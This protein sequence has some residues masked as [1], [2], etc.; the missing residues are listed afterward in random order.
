MPRA[1]LID[2]DGTLV[3]PIPDV[4]LAVAGLLASEQLP[5]LSQDQVRLMAARAPRV[6]ERRARYRARG[7]FAAVQPGRH[8]RDLPTSVRPHDVDARRAGR[9]AVLLG[10]GLY[11]GAG[12]QLGPGRHRDD[13]P[14]F[15][16]GRLVHRHHRGQQR[17]CDGDAGALA[18]TGHSDRSAAPPGRVTATC[19]DDRQQRRRCP[20]CQ[21]RRCRGDR[22]SRRLFERAARDFFARC[23]YRHHW[24]GACALRARLTE[25]AAG[26]A[27]RPRRCDVRH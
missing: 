4:T 18:A 26:P 2:L 16:R 21:G 15:R 19:R 5:P 14:T 27:S 1:V 12:N 13:P 22:G 9:A 23:H 3:G 10:E 24:R 20:T 7:G 6:L 25:P 8:D 11:D 17:A